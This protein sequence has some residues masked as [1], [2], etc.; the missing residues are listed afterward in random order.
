[1]AT[2]SVGN[3][4]INNNVRPEYYIK[5]L[6]LRLWWDGWETNTQK[7]QK[8]GWS[9]T[10]E[11]DLMSGSFRILLKHP[12]K[13]YM[14]SDAVNVNYYDLH[15]QQQIMS[16]I[17]VP[18]RRV[19]SSMHIQLVERSFSFKPIDAEPFVAGQVKSVE[20][21]VWFSPPLIKTNEIIVPDESV[22]DLLRRI[23]EKQDPLLKKY[24]KEEVMRGN[25]EGMSLSE[26]PPGEVKFQAQIIS[27]PYARRAA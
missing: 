26:L 25:Y 23:L 3:Q 7:L 9:L 16:T 6:P 4:H 11:Q 8:A 22:D 21:L 15:Q 17:E 13:L 27:L 20:D 19:S 1:M 18:I 14:L 24:Y 10:A 2:T 5:N 12:Q